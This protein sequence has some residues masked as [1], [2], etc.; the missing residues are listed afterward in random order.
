[1]KPSASTIL[2]T[3]F[4]TFHFSV[5]VD[6]DEKEHVVLFLGDLN[7]DEPVLVRVQSEC[8]TGEVFHS[9]ACEC[10]PQLVTALKKINA[11]GRGILIYLRQE[12]RDIGLTNKIKAYELQR[13]G[14][15]TVQAN[16]KLG[17]PPDARTYQTAAMI[18]KNLGI[19]SVDLMTNNPDK[20]K[21]LEG[22]GIEVHERIPIEISPNGIDDTYLTVKKNKLG[23]VLTQV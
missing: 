15:D 9:L 1:M 12:G 22:F 18:L 5:Y 4:G 19:K 3:E 6:K 10:G 16:E 8:L 14:L 20:V 2:Q 7:T 23:H 17:F 11:Q 13:Q 21:Q